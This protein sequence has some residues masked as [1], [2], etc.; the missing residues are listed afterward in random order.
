MTQYFDPNLSIRRMVIQKGAANVYDEKFH[1]GVNIIRGENASGKSTVLNFIFY[2]LGGDLADWSE[3]ASLC[4]RVYVEAI[5]CGKVITVSRAVARAHG[6]PMD[7]FFGSYESSLSTP[8]TEWGRYPYRRSVNKESFSQVL[9]RALD[10]PEA[11]SDESG[12]ITMHQVMRL[13]YADQLSMTENLF[14]T[15]TF[16]PAGLREAVGRLL[17]GAFD[18]EMYASQGELKDID[19]RYDTV[20]G[21]LNSLYHALG[22][23]GH[24]LT[25]NWVVEQ[26]NRLNDDR[27][28]VEIQIAELQRSASS[29]KADEPS[30]WAQRE[31]YDVLVRAQEKLAAL[32]NQR[33]SLSFAVAD[34]DSFISSMRDKLEALRDSALTAQ[35][36]G[37]AHFSTCPACYAQLS[38]AAEGT[39]VLCK[40]PFDAE[41]AVE[42]VASLTNDTAL[43]L[44][45]SLLLQEV[46]REKLADA[47]AAVDD[48][49]SEWELAARRYSQVQ[50]RPT[51]EYAHQLNE[52]HKALGYL[53]RRGEDLTEKA[54]M[55]E[56]VESLSTQKA[57]LL[58]RSTSLREKIEYLRGVQEGRLLEAAFAISEEIKTLLKNDLE[59]EPAFKDPSS[60]EFSFAGNKIGVDGQSYFSASSRAVLKSSFFVGFHA[61]AANKSFFRH[62]RFCMLDTIEDKGMEPAR[63]QNFQREIVRVAA[64][65][66][67]ENQIIFATAMIADDLN[68][69]KYT[70][71]RY[72]TRNDRALKFDA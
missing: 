49:K 6:Q 32:A 38:V 39:C 45:Q 31:T 2:G 46:R 13:L 3:T 68:N 61:A 66:E 54:K 42:R 48:A 26:R 7:V 60:V 36:I 65:A 53:D 64:S 71:G 57:D 40:K 37:A 50:R 11:V 8:Q 1:P 14:R 43:Q 29:R 33:D 22:Q 4:D 27:N 70:V 9:F 19:R 5:F 23:A 34:S 41:E 20:S 10:M 47:I 55:M 62:P 72:Y 67:S 30:L 21:E 35:S 17:C 52:L 51:N 25:L 69:D 24:D 44:K 56:I 58:Y 15:E 28:K 63:S 12:S 16:D 18:N 59:R